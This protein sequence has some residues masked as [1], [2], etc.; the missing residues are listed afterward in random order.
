MIFSQ[1]ALVYSGIYRNILGENYI[2]I[3]APHRRFFIP[4]S[5]VYKN[6][7]NEYVTI[8]PLLYISRFLEYKKLM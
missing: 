2:Y 7:A 3:H 1:Y 8:S 5:K 4:M 6:T